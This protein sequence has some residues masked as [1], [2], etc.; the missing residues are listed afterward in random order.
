MLTDDAVEPEVEME[1]WNDLSTDLRLQIEDQ[2]GSFVAE[3]QVTTGHN[4]LVGMVLQTTQGKF[5]LKGVRADHSRAVW[6]QANE[7]AINKHVLPFAA[8]LSFHI[9]AENWD[10]L[11]FQYLADYRLADLSPGSPDLPKIAATLQTLSGGS[12]HPTRSSSAPWKTGSVA[13]AT[14]CPSWRAR[15]SPTPTR[16]ATTS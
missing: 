1:S 4:C 7:A 6:T 13:T 16:I 11:G 15:R 5:F 10:I 3:E 9:R 2:V 12:R 14:T 8:E